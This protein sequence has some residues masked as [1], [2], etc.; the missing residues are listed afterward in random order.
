M[1]NKIYKKWYIL[2]TLAIAGFLFVGFIATSFGNIDRWFADVMGEGMQINFVKFWVVF[3]NEMGFTS[4]F[5]V[6]SISFLIVIEAFYLR[7]QGKKSVYN[8]IYL[9]YFV[10]IIFFLT[11]NLIRLVGVFNENTGWGPGIDV[12]YLTNNT[13]KSAARISI[14]IIETMILI[15]WILFL[16]LKLSK[17]R[18]LI[19]NRVWITAI[20]ALVFGII[21]FL[22]LTL[23][24]KQ[25]FGRP[26]YLNVEFEK[27]IGKVELDDSGWAIDIELT[28]EVQKLEVD[29]PNIKEQILQ[30]YNTGGY[31]TQAD[32]Y[33]KWYEINGNWYQNIKFWPGSK[34]FT[35]ILPFDPN[36][37]KPLC[38]DNRDFPSGHTI[39]G[40]TGIYYVLFADSIVKNQKNKRWITITLFA[41]WLVNELSMINL[42]VVART[43]YVSDTWFSFVFCT[44]ALI[45]SLS[46]TNKLA[47]KIVLK[48]RN[49]SLKENNFCILNNRIYIYYQNDNKILISKFGTK[50]SEKKIKK[51]LNETQV[52]EIIHS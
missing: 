13:F 46:V 9:C 32:R 43:H 50:K 15:F 10:V 45:W 21:S 18:V 26:Y 23:I 37:T 24:L 42:L 35:W 8:T 28:P 48:I 41:I 14:F 7:F 3:Y 33:Y 30:S 12:E 22:I 29:Y 38:W 39:S 44:I 5:L 34:W 11:Y 52:N 36:Y 16:R 2:T 19:E 49:K 25:T 6:M 40:F 20:S 4:L 17:S 47:T 51:Y 27:Y 31:W 1:T